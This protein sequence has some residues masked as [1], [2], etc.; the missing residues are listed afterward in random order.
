[1]IQNF[2]IKLILGVKPSKENFQWSG[3]I[4]SALVILTMYFIIIYG[5]FF[6]TIDT[7]IE[8]SQQPWYMEISAKISFLMIPLRIVS[9][10][11]FTKLDHMTERY[12]AAFVTQLVGLVGSTVI[13]S[14]LNGF[15]KTLPNIDSTLVI[16][17][18]LLPYTLTLIII[19][20]MHYI[21][22]K[23]NFKLKDFLGPK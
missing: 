4:P 10:S 13:N 1:M 2:I 11:L 21:Y 8:L 16:I 19:A 15:I 6:D 14:I 12:I 20:M 7:M 17:Y 5:N 23:K 9:L 18:S 22:S 3:L